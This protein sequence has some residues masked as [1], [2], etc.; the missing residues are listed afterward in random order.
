MK[1]LASV[2]AVILLCTLAISGCNVENNAYVATVNGEKI[3]VEEFMYFLEMSKDMIM[4]QAGAAALT[5]DFWNTTDFEGQKAGEAAKEKALTE[6]VNS[7]LLAQA[8]KAEGFK[9]DATATVEVNQQKQ[10]FGTQEQYQQILTTYNLTDRGVTIV[11][12]KS[13][14]ANKLIEKWNEDPTFMPTD[15][16]ATKY[17]NENYMHAKHI[18]I[19]FQDPETGAP[20]DEEEA[21]KTAEDVLK[22]VKDG[23]DFDALMKEYS[24]GPG[25]ET[26][27]NG[28]TFGPDQMVKEFESATKA[29]EVGKVS[30]LVLS[31]YG[32]HII[33]REALPSVDQF[34]EE[35]GGTLQSITNTL[36][37]EKINQ[38]IEEMKASATIEKN[39]AEWDK[40]EVK[41]NVQP[42][43]QDPAAVQ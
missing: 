33:K 18:L 10:N 29:L 16:E 40:I 5:E 13:Y 25:L 38:K 8:A 41:N 28:Y 2:I 37:N 24:K 9:I 32:Y 14:L 22:K 12:E 20:L 43:G 34:K 30:E 7:E 11:L 1:K 27:P 21:K 42:Q 35:N 3:L 4:N 23:G 19:P 17:Y 15:E 39:Q 31:S 6:N 26:S 36:A